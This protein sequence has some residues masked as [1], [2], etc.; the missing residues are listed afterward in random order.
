MIEYNLAKDIFSYC[1]RI[2]KKD[3]DICCP[4]PPKGFGQQHYTRNSSLQAKGS[5]IM[6]D[7]M[8]RMNI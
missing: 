8:I 7:S 2:C 6:D 4:N 1:M 5:L 3:G